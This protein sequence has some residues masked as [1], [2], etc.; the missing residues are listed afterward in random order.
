MTT[1]YEDLLELGE[2]Y[3]L[4]Q[5]YDEAIKALKKAKKINNKDPKLYYTLGIVFEALNEREDAI[6]NFRLALS[7]DPK[8]KSAQE[9]LD[10]LIHK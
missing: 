7:L 2:F 5:K 6:S 4:S 8:H 3:I 9:H 1:K 10:N